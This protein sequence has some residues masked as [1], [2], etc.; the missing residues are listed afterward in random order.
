MGSFRQWFAIARFSTTLLWK[1][2]PGRLKLARSNSESLPGAGK[3]IMQ[4]EAATK[5]NF[6]NFPVI[7]APDVSLKSDDVSGEYFPRP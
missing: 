5:A 3:Q 7:L 1:S 2:T 6:R 4:R